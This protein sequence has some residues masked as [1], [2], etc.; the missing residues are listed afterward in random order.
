MEKEQGQIVNAFKSSGGTK[1]QR[2]KRGASE[3]VALP[4]YKRL[5]V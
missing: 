5:L 3:L 4:C 1:R 2:K